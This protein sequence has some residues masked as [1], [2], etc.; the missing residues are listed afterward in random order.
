MNF[1]KNKKIYFINVVLA[2]LVFLIALYFNKISP[3]G[4][5][6]IGKSD[7]SVQFK[8]MIYNLIMKMKTGTLLNYSFNNGLGNPTAFDFIYYI[9]SPFNLVALLFNN[10]NMMYLIV[11]LTKIAICAI[12]TTFYCKKKTDNYYIIFI[13]TMSYVFSSW[14]LA[15]YYY[16]PW[17]DVYMIFPLFQYGLE[18]LLDK[19][20]YNIYIFSLAYILSTNFYLAFPVCLYTLLYFII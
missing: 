13:S 19:H 3:F 6:M 7:A 5:M 9:A 11:T 18:E 14:F 4:N 12:T 2:I 16:T 8:P 20:K 15:Y 10:P 17:L 1:L